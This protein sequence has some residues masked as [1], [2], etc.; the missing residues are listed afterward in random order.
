M[1]SV[2]LN[3]PEFAAQVILISA[4]GVLSPGPLFFANLLYGSKG[5]AMSGVKL[6]YGHTTVELPIVILLAVGLFSYPAFA[7]RYASVI[8]LVGGAGI[9]GFAILQGVSFAQSKGGAEITASGKLGSLLRYRKSSPVFVGAA[10][11]ALNPFFLTWWFTAGL[12]LILDS[13][14][15]GVV[16]GI[17]LLFVFHIWMD[18]AWLAS[19]AHLASK[20][21]SVLKSRYYMLIYYGVIA[22]LACYG[23]Y[24][25]INSVG[26]IIQ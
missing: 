21:K 9:I 10:L 18:Y 4:S 26:M 24:F 15:F 16:T 6:A 8:G 14:A 17:V 20:G 1:D 11:S 2:G 19:T 25:V 13:F 5:A 23:V 22:A 3:I 7:D 12:K